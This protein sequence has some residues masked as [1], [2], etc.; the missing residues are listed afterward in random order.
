MSTNLLGLARLIRIELIN[1]MVIMP[2]CKK[3]LLTPLVKVKCLSGPGGFKHNLKPSQEF[4]KN[5]L[6]CPSICVY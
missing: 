4:Y 1:V 2:E 3:L 5:Y 6:I